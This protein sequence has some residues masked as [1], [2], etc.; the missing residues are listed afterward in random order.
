M[1][2][3]FVTIVVLLL[4]VSCGKEPKSKTETL[5]GTGTETIEKTQEVSQEEAAQTLND[6]FN[7]EIKID[8]DETV[9]VIDNGSNRVTEDMSAGIMTMLAPQP[10]G[11]LKEQLEKE[12]SQE[13]YTLVGIE[14]I[15]IE[16]RIVL[17]QKSMMVDE[18]GD[19]M[20]MMMHALPAGDKTMMIS[21][22][23]PKAEESKY[24]P[25]IEKAVLSA[26]LK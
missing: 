1:R 17:Q 14:E 18:V 22:F 10:Y 26:K 4:V 25:L 5:S 2:K 13:G 16:G 23:Y 19:E 21:S 11:Q 20:I 24:L 3:Y 12:P 9:F 6:V 7:S 15:E 8:V